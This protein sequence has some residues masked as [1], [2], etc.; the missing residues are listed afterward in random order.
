[1]KPNDTFAF[2]TNFVAPEQMQGMT[3]RD[4]IAVAVLPELMRRMSNDWDAEQIQDAIADAY[5]TADKAL[6]MRTR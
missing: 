1:M 4:Y 3:L 6:K 5:W 2:P